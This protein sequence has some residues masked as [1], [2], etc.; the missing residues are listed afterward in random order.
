MSMTT[1]VRKAL[2]HATLAGSIGTHGFRTGDPAQQPCEGVEAPAEA[3]RVDELAD[4]LGR[5]GA[6]DDAGAK[7]V[8]VGRRPRQ[9]LPKRSLELGLLRRVVEAVG[10]PGLVL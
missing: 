3:D 9:R 10:S 8:S 6:G 1:G 2:S 4:D 5:V 7:Y